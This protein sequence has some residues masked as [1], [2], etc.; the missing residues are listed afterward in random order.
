V[1]QQQ[2]QAEIDAVVQSLSQYAKLSDITV[3]VISSQ[4]S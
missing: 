1:E 2:R 4:P 3:P